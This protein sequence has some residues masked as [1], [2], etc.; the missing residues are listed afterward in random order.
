M[1]FIA[2]ANNATRMSATINAA[3]CRFNASRRACRRISRGAFSLRFS[4]I[5]VANL[6]SSWT[7]RTTATAASSRAVSAWPIAATI[8][9][10]VAMVPASGK[11]SRHASC[12]NCWRLVMLARRVKA[13]VTI[14]LERGGLMVKA[15]CLV[16]RAGPW[17]FTAGSS[18]T[19]RSDW[20]RPRPSARSSARCARPASAKTKVGHGGTLD[21]LASAC[22]RSRWAKRPSLRDGCSMRPRPMISP[23]G[24]ARRPTRS[25][26]KGKSSPPAT[27]GRRMRRRSRPS[28]R[29][30][31]AR[32]TRCRRPFRR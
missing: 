30:S 8:T 13:R 19:S 25:T 21:P 18:S 27:C 14:L 17:R 12:C 23:S 4:G 29:A 6:V 7:A 11:Y 16:Y 24:S 32:S 2:S 10:Q 28:C 31:P 9:A 22:C 3:D 26:W 20:A 1:L 5:G 15:G